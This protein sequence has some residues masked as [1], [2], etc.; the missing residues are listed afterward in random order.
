MPLMTEA[1]WNEALK[2]ASWGNQQ[3]ATKQDPQ[4]KR[5][6]KSMTKVRKTSDP[7]PYQKKMS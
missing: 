4:K 6:P 5:V 2:N 3:N 1:K 7:K